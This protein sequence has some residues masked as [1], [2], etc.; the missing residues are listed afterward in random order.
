MIRECMKIPLAK[1]DITEMEKAYV[2]DVLESSQLSIGPYI[3]DF[4][5]SMT[6]YIGVKH[7]IAVNSGT[8]ALHLIVKSLGIGKGDEVITTPFTFVASTNC[9]LYE[10]ARPV[11]VDIDPITL[12]M[13]LD[14]VED[15]ITHKTKAILGVDIF[16]YPLDWERLNDISIGYNLSLIDDSCEALGAKIGDIMIGAWADA[17]AFAFY[18]NKQI[19]TG[20]GGMI[21]TEDD[22]IADM[23]RSA[24]NQGRAG[25]GKWLVHDTLGYNCRLD[26]MSCALG[27]AQ[28]DRIGSIMYKRQKV[29]DK[30]ISELSGIDGVTVP[31]VPKD[32]TRSWFV[33]V[34]LVDNRDE[35]MRK[36]A[37]RGIQTNNYF[38]PVHLQPL[39]GYDEGTFP[40]AESISKRT[41]AL[42]F[43]NNMTD[44]EIEY[45]VQNLK[46]VM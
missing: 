14:K 41:L 29:A 43:Y 22:E 18:P 28:M 2:R 40:V 44:N 32:A 1:P 39:Y 12:N 46:E 33:F 3:E 45:V 26:E 25:S 21:L 13:D 35:I 27:L 19:T 38:P 8:S 4:E 42:P 30:Y 36:L 11:F 34:I 6:K 24:R 31:P 9:I 23:C 5:K 37:D 15:V 16:G 17:S 7:A 10:G 20:E